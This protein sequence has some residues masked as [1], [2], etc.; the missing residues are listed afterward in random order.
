MD[1]YLQSNTIHYFIQIIRALTVW[2]SFRLA[3]MSL[4]VQDLPGYL[5]FFLPNPRIS[6]LPEP[7][8]FLLDKSLRNHDLGT[9]F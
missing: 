3:P 2:S 5:T 6:H 9:T 4:Q 8:F 1:I 7:L